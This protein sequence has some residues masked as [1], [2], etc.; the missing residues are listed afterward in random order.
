MNLK[1]M[2][3]RAKLILAFGSLALMVLIASAIAINALNSSNQQFVSFVSGIDTR[4]HLVEHIHASVG[5]RAI[6]VRNMALATSQADIDREKAVAVKAHEEV[7]KNLALLDS[8]VA[9]NDIPQN[10]KSLVAD[11]DKIE[12]SYTPV[13][14]AIVDLA[15]QNK[16]EEAIAKI[17][18]ECLPLLTAL[19]EKANAYADTTAGRS[20]ALLAEAEEQYRNQRT[21][22][23]RSEERRV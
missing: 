17:N 12:Q 4:A 23:I 6:A 18:N 5:E 16:R 7:H 8:M 9:G 21:L 3:V 15:S 14:L 22:L 13:A 11:I 1:N 2:T 10:V 19:I 20:Q